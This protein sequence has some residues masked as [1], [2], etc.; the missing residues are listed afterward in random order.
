MCAGYTARTVARCI[1]LAEVCGIQ[2]SSNFYVACDTSDVAPAVNLTVVY[3]VDNAAV[4]KVRGVIGQAEN[5]SDT[6]I[7]ANVTV[8]Y[9]VI[10]ATP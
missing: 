7:T 6:I 5:T 2:Y 4:C 8:V 3:T 10:D 9:T 1:N